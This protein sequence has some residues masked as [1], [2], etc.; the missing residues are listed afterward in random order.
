MA[1]HILRA[2]HADEAA[3]MFLENPAFRAQGSIYPGAIGAAH[4]VWEESHSV[5]Y[6]NQSKSAGPVRS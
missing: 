2:H 4:E 3:H 5:R 6:S 1:N